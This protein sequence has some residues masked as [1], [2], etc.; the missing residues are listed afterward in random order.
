[1]ICKRNGCNGPINKAGVV[2]LPVS[3]SGW[4]TEYMQAYPCTI[5]G[6]LH[7]KNGKPIRIKNGSKAFLIDNEIVFL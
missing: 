4:N 5:C 1:M 7:D 2:S 6:E 3:S